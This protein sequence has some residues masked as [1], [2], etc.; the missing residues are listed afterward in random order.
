[1]LVASNAL[2]SIHA[3]SC[4]WCHF[5]NSYRNLIAIKQRLFM[6]QFLSSGSSGLLARPHQMCLAVYGLY[7]QHKSLEIGFK[8]NFQVLYTVTG[9]VLMQL[10]ANIFT[11]ENDKM[12][13]VGSTW[14]YL[15]HGWR[16]VKANIDGI[17]RSCK[18]PWNEC[19]ME[20]WTL[21]CS[22]QLMNVS[23]HSQLPIFI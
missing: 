2:H 13:A 15:Y 22:M 19:D 9:I 18:S 4:T 6:G 12:S 20:M 3:I 8:L 23:L 7:R 16:C 5:T 10:R 17:G 11:N 21:M 1:M 14:A